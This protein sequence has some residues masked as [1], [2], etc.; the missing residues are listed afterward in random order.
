MNIFD[1]VTTSFK[2]SLMRPE[3]T[4]RRDV[5]ALLSQLADTLRELPPSEIDAIIFH[6]T[7]IMEEEAEDMLPIFT[8]YFSTDDVAG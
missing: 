6:R 3:G 2:F 8:V 4:D 5:P 1:G 7:C